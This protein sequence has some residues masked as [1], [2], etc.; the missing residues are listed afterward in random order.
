MNDYHS[1]YLKCG[2]WLL[3]DVFKNFRNKFRKCFKLVPRCN[4]YETIK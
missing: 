1:L 4:I 2:V 3:A